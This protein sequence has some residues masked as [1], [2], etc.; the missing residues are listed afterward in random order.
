[1]STGRPY[2]ERTRSEAER[3][4]R[5]HI[6]H[7][8]GSYAERSPIAFAKRFGESLV[9][10]AEGEDLILLEAEAVV[11][12][13]HGGVGLDQRHDLDGGGGEAFP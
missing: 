9:V 1:M 7:R 2:A 3:S 8:P 11:E 5:G 10:E 4:P 13:E 12:V 6:E